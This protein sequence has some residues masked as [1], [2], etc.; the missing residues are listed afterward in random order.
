MLGISHELKQIIYGEIFKYLVGIDKPYTHIVFVLTTAFTG[1]GVNT[2]G[3]RATTKI[4]VSLTMDV[5][6][7]NVLFLCL[8]FGVA[9]F[10]YYIKHTAHATQNPQTGQL[11]HFHRILYGI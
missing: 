8:F 3:V 6:F 7:L 9:F 10:L 4:R 1:T 11:I 2:S 5:N